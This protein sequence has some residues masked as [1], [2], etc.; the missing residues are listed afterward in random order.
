[1]TIILS[2]WMQIRILGEMSLAELRQALFETLHEIEDEYRL[3]HSFGAVL[4][5]NPTDGLGEKIVARNKLGRRAEK[6]TKKGAYRS[7]ADEYDPR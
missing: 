5:I 2:V 3:R 1:M 7:A 6:V 4:F